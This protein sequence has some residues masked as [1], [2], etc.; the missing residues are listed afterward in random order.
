MSDQLQ[1]ESALHARAVECVAGTLTEMGIS[2]H[3]EATARA[4]LARLAS[5]PEPILLATP[6]ELEDR[7]PN[8]E[9]EKRAADFR[10]RQ[11]ATEDGEPDGTREGLEQCVRMLDTYAPECFPANE[12][13]QV[14]FARAMMESVADEIREFLKQR[15]AELDRLRLLLIRKNEALSVF[16][17]PVMWITAT[18]FGP[19]MEW[20]G[21]NEYRNPMAFARREAEATEPCDTEGRAT[22]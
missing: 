6:A 9:H 18:A 17:S 21:D 8:P 22:T 10:A 11:R 15:D 20:N 3:G 5:L 16:A 4:I 19:R 14:H 1:R 12:Q 7:E 2:K 13:G